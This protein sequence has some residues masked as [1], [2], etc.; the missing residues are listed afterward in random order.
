MLHGDTVLEM[1]DYLSCL[2]IK[3]SGAASMLSTMGLESLANNP[4]ELKNAAS[5]MLRSW[6]NIEETI[7]I[8]VCENDDLGN[9]DNAD[10][11]TESQVHKVKILTQTLSMLK[12]IHSNGA[13]LCDNVIMLKAR[14]LCTH[15]EISI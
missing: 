4:Q 10:E 14:E 15:I 11:Q 12:E 6:L 3:E 5:A 13:K 7:M 8:D 2:T 9:Y 1:C